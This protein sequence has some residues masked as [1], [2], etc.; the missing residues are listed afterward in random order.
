MTINV[1][2]D[3]AGRFRKA[4]AAVMGK[5]K[6]K[7]GKAVAEALDSWSSKAEQD[8]VAEAIKLLEKGVDMGGLKYK[9]RF[10]LYDRV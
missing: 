10:E 2:E 1:S 3:V 6:G 4:V 7:L 8:P 9:H 5:G